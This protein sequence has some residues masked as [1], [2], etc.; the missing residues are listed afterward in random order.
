MLP[1][2]SQSASSSPSPPS[3]F[4]SHVSSSTQK[5]LVS[6]GSLEFHTKGRQ[7]GKLAE[8]HHHHP[9]SSSS[10]SISS[11]LVELPLSDEPISTNGQ[12]RHQQQQD[13]GHHTCY[14]C[15]PPDKT[16]AEEILS[17]FPV[18][19]RQHIRDCAS[20]GSHTANLFE[21][22]CPPEYVGCLLRIHGEFLG[23]LISCNML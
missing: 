6:S 20:F 15:L 19:T 7:V 1:T 3:H 17:I 4:S 12:Q 10:L 21:F 16:D 2:T 13:Y 18:E 8:N 14:V 23:F 11:H 5:T 22:K 9:R